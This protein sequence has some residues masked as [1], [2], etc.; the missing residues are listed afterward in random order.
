[1]DETTLK[2]LKD[3]IPVPRHT[4]NFILSRGVAW[5]LANKSYRKNN[6]CLLAIAY[7]IFNNINYIPVLSVMV[8]EEG[9][10]TAFAFENFEIFYNAETGRWDYEFRISDEEI[11]KLYGKDFQYYFGM[12]VSAMNVDLV[13]RALVSA[14]LD[15]ELKNTI[16][17]EGLRVLYTV[18]AAR[19]ETMKKV[20][21]IPR[22][23]VWYK[24]K[25]KREE[26]EIVIDKKLVEVADTIKELA[27]KYGTST[28]EILRMIRNLLT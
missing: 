11:V 3:Y 28:E 22:V 13:C 24:P 12:I 10:P 9:N 20:R 4:L 19:L 25:A 16:T 14:I 18:A 5:A 6:P 17:K 1:M 27:E 15:Y 21:E 26:K 2:P 23:R 7:Q 8:D